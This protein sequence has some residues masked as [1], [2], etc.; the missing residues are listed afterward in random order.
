MN[1]CQTRIAALQRLL[2]PIIPTN[3][4]E[5]VGR[6]KITCPKCNVTSP[7]TPL[8]KDGVADAFDI[9]PYGYHSFRCRADGHTPRTKLLHDRLRD[10]WIS[11]FR[12]AGFIATR[13]PRSAIQE[14]NKRP[15]A[16]ISL[17]GMRTL[18]LDIR[19]CDPL[20][21]PEV[22]ACSH[23]IGHAANI[24][25]AIKDH[26]WLELVSGQGDVFQAICHEHP[27]RIGLVALSALERAAAKF[28]QT[29]PQRNAFKTYWLQ[30]LHMV[31]TRGVADVIL[32]R[33]PFEDQTFLSRTLP[34]PLPHFSHPN[35]QPVAFP[36][37]SHSTTTQHVVDSLI[38]PASTLGTQLR[39]ASYYARAVV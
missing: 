35:P 27:G 33:L 24:G 7:K 2:I 4:D 13:E 1:N 9:D 14:S 25:A 31:N 38:L 10:V 15:D 30:R 20:K 37:S 26:D 22:A 39:D 18:F 3:I 6:A 8:T 5:A 11:I 34:D 19:T 12:H 23:T 29:P 16:A 36:F 21:S 28:G 32:Q 17:E